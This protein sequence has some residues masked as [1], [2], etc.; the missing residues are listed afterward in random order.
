MSANSV[1]PSS[2]HMSLLNDAPLST[3][4]SLSNLLFKLL[5][6][7]S[8]VLA[9]GGRIFIYEFL[10]IFDFIKMVWGE[11]HVINELDVYYLPLNEILYGAMNIVTYQSHDEL[12]RHFSNGKDAHTKFICQVLEK[13][14]DDREFGRR[15]REG[16]EGEEREEDDCIVA[17]QKIIDIIKGIN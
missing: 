16:R 2:T 13:I 7:H 8:H 14:L 12:V 15:N 4:T 17:S 5:D 10:M 9:L 1:S 11:D 6:V 3:H